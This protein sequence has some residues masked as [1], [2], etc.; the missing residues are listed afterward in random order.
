MF[1]ENAKQARDRL[2][3]NIGRIKGD[4]KEQLQRIL[5]EITEVCHYSPWKLF[6]SLN[7]SVITQLEL[8]GFKVTKCVYRND[9]YYVSWD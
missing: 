5:E 9:W 3:S 6:P 1:I 8:K 4:D 2:R 7:R